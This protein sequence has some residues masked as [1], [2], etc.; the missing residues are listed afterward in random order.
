MLTY[1]VK[2]VR[3]YYVIPL[4]DVIK[5]KEHNASTLGESIKR[6][7]REGSANAPD[8]IGSSSNVLY[9][10]RGRCWLHAVAGA[11]SSKGPNELL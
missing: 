8:L 1:Y 7:M 10:D 4:G 11:K 6:L 9:G 2:Y 5:R 3:I